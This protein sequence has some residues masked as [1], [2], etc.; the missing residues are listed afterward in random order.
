[1]STIEKWSFSSICIVG[2]KK[3][4]IENRRKEKNPKKNIALLHHLAEGHNLGAVRRAMIRSAVPD[5]SKLNRSNHFHLVS[6]LCSYYKRIVQLSGTAHPYLGPFLPQYTKRLF[7]PLHT[8]HSPQR[9]HRLNFQAFY[10]S[11]NLH[12]AVYAICC[13]IVSLLLLA[14]YSEACGII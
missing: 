10:S 2:L 14:V 9:P 12:H 1:M 11:Y 8:A 4:P 5:R 13:A 3:N 7:F 6:K